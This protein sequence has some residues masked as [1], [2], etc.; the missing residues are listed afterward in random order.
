M[1]FDPKNLTL[2]GIASVHRQLPKELRSAVKEFAGPI[3]EVIWAWNYCHGAF[4]NLFGSLIAPHRLNAAHA[5]WHE[6]QN[7]TTQRSMLLAA[8]RVLLAKNPKLLR[9]I[10]W[11]KNTADKL[12]MIRNDFAHLG[13]SFAN[14]PHAPSVVPDY[15]TTMPKRYRRLLGQDLK[16]V[17]PALIGDLIALAGYVISLHGSLLS[18]Q[19]YPLPRKPTM[20]S[21]PLHTG[22]KKNRRKSRARRRPPQSSLA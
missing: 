4:A 9:R 16:K 15:L 10:E 17:P 7:D 22:K 12:S 8:A 19:H 21:I 6:V 13:T 11:A 20:R 5:I 2:T 1:A 14:Y 18:P 3:G